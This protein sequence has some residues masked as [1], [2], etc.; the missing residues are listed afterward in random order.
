MRSAVPKVERDPGKVGGVTSVGDGHIEDDLPALAQLQP[1]P[2]DPGGG[3]G[4]RVL[5]H[6]NL[7]FGS[8]P[9]LTDVVFPAI[10]HKMSR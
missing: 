3:R 8:Q 2:R 10:L 9:G 5:M 6:H 1:L 7:D 4:H